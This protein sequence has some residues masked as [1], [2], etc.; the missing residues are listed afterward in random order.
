MKKFF[1]VVSTVLFGMHLWLPIVYSLIF[2]MIAAISGTIVGS[3]PYYFIGLALS[4]A[5]SLMLVYFLKDKKAKKE[6]ST[7]EVSLTQK[8]KEP[9]TPIAPQSERTKYVLADDRRD[10]SEYVAAEQ[11]RYTNRMYAEP[12]A[13]YEA[14][15]PAS[16]P[17]DRPV[18]DYGYG[19]D[20]S[21]PTQ[22]EHDGVYS[23]FSSSPSTSAPEPSQPAFSPY[24]QP[25][26][27]Q[28]DRTI[29]ISDYEAARA[30]REETPKIFRT[31]ANPNLL[32]YEYSDRYEKYEQMP[33]GERRFISV[34]RK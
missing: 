5:G 23:S 12:G 25:Q 8:P 15:R 31:R 20:Y 18:S 29:S 13:Y 32:I 14:P 26:N 34:E 1:Q 3:W 28:S 6:A 17:E 21:R 22:S 9:E 30:R 11:A 10:A 33:N 7:A 2:L 4:F 16:R 27:A 24:L 19:N